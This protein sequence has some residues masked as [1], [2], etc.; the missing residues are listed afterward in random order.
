MAKKETAPKLTPENYIRQKAKSLPIYE[1]YVNKGWDKSQMATIIVSRVHTT[2]NITM[3][4]YLV[5]LLCLGVKDSFYKFNIPEYEFRDILTSPS[6]EHLELSEIPYVLAHN[7]I[8]GAVS[9]AED[10]GFAPDKVFSSITVHM[11]EEDTDEVE[12][13]ELDFGKN[14]K[15]FYM[16]GP[17]DSKLKINQIIST[18]EKT[19]GQGNYLFAVGEDEYDEYDDDDDYKYDD[20]PL[21]RYDKMS[22]EEKKALYLE[23]SDKKAEDMDKGENIIVLCSSILADLADADEVNR[24]FEDYDDRLNSYEILSPDDL[25][26]D[27]LMGVSGI[28]AEINQ[29]L[30]EIYYLPD[31]DNK[32]AAKMLDKLKDE[33]PEDVP[34]VAFLESYILFKRNKNKKFSSLREK[35][36]EKYPDYH[37]IKLAE[38]FEDGEKNYSVPYPED[39]FKGREA[40]H[41]IELYVFLIYLVTSLNNATNPAVIE[42]VSLV[43]EDFLDCISEEESTIMAMALTLKQ[44]NYVNNYFSNN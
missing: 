36:L 28:D 2:G 12:L 35:Y 3:T 40:I 37:I 41:P 6:F 9:F 34:F 20:T 43:C 17:D 27:E 31:E 32:K 1:C 24:F 15:P 38:C 29:K 7:I 18:L 11:L 5:D 26:P 25:I 44:I 21:S 33:L 39:F 10:Y 13:I 42:G 14:G 22:F 16:Q 23:L 4:S 8:Y 19:A 30:V